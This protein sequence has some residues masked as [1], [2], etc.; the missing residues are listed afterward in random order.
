MADSIRHPRRP[1]EGTAVI[2]QGYA[3][4][5]TVALRL[6]HSERGAKNL[7]TRYGVL[8][9]RRAVCYRFCVVALL[10]IHINRK[11]VKSYEKVLLFERSGS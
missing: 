9:N 11:E 4:R 7:R 6:R 8:I 10:G 2:V 5:L 1:R 3:N